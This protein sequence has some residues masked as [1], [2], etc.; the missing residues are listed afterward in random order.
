MVVLIYAC[1]VQHDRA[2]FSMAVLR[3]K[4]SFKIEGDH[5]P[6]NP[7]LNRFSA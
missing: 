5:F 7:S 4:Y 6:Q 2:T 1:E 3:G